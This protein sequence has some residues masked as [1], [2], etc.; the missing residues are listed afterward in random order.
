MLASCKDDF[1]LNK[2]QGTDKLVV[3]CFPSTADTTW[4]NVSRSVPVQQR[5]KIA[6]LADIPNAIVSYQVN[7][8]QRPITKKADGLFYAVG[9]QQPGD[10]ITLQVKAEGYADVASTTTVPRQPAIKADDVR[11]VHIVDYY[12]NHN[13]MQQVRATFTDNAAT[14]DYYA[15]R[16]RIKRITGYVY[17][18]FTDGKGTGTGRWPTQ[19]SFDLYRKQH[20]YQWTKVEVRDLDSTYTYSDIDSASDPLL[21]PTSNIDSD[22]GFESD[23]YQN[24]YIF[25]DAAINGQ[26]YTM[27]LNSNIS[28]GYNNYDGTWARAYNFAR[29]C[30]VEIYRI[31]PEYYR[32][33][34]SLNSVNGNDLAAWGLAQISPTYSNIAGGIGVMGAFNVYHSNW[35]K[36]EA[37]MQY[38]GSISYMPY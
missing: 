36:L 5:Q 1:N 3:Y 11:P 18:E 17:A 32:F 34:K 22:F 21:S 15:V 26:T 8:Q 20:D 30:Q 4:I 2:M 7:G 31:T 12:G 6:Q 38:E 16:L 25:E 24:F 13:D 9:T 14:K 27:H 33:L 10:K 28:D 37:S 19:E 23:F 35:V 29:Y